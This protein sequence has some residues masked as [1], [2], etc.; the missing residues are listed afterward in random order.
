MGDSD[1]ALLFWPGLLRFN[2]LFLSFSLNKNKNRNVS[3]CSSMA[4]WLPWGWGGAGVPTAGSRALCVGGGFYL[5]V[6]YFRHR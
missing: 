2:A 4:E 1:Q 3:G 5:F 6:F